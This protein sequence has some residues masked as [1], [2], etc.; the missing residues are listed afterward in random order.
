MA[1]VWFRKALRLHDNLALSHAVSHG[2]LVFPIFILDPYFDHSKIGVNR[3]QF[4]LESL[5][6][7][8]DL[9]EPFVSIWPFARSYQRADD[10]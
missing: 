9:F 6:D 8:S 7:L 2:D 1:G 5:S 3:F 4:L 10:P